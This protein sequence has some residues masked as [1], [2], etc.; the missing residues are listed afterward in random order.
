MRGLRYLFDATTLRLVKLSPSMA[1][2]GRADYERVKLAE[3][4]SVTATAVTFNPHW[5]IREM[6]SWH[7]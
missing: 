1:A 2:A 5:S 7:R 6:D 3:S 4:I